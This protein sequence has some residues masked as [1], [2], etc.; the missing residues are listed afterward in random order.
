MISA[1]SVG[2][3]FFLGGIWMA[4][5]MPATAFAAVEETSPV[6]LPRE[7]EFFLPSHPDNPLQL[8]HRLLETGTVRLQVEGQP[9]T[10][11]EDFKV[12]ARS[13]II[14]PLQPWHSGQEPSLVV[15]RYRYLPAGLPVRRDLW[16]VSPAPRR[17]ASGQLIAQEQTG[18][19]GAAWR[20]GQLNVTG[21]KTVQVNSGSRREMTVDQNLRLTILGQLTE[22]IGVRAFLSD[23]N[24]PVI[25]EGNTEELRDIDKVLVE[26]RAKRWEATLGDF[27]AQRKG[28]TFGDYRRKLQGFSVQTRSDEASV[29]VLAGSPRGLYKTLQVRGQEANQGPYYLGA[30]AGA[31]NLFIVA[32]SERVTLDGERLTRGADRDYTID[33]VA[34]TVTFTFRR[35]ITAESTIVVEYEQGEGPFGRTVVGAGA[36]AEFEVPGLRWQGRFKARIIRERDDPHRLRTG[37]LSV[38]DEAVLATAGD[39]PY[40]AVAVGVQVVEGSLGLYDRTEDSGKTIYIYNATGGDYDLSLYFVGNGE[41]DYVLDFITETGQRI[42]RHKGDGLGNYRIGR[43]LD[44]PQQQSMT[45]LTAAVGDTTGSH[46]RAE[47]NFSDMDENLLS[48]QDDGDNQATAGRLEGRWEQQNLVAGELHVTGFHESQEA[49][50]TPFQVHKTVFDFDRWGLSDRARRTGFIAE[51]NMETGAS[52]RWATGG[53]DRSMEFRGAWGRLRHGESVEAARSSGQLGWKVLG[54]LGEHYESRAKAQDGMDPLDIQRTSRQHLLRWQ[55]GPIQPEIRYR[56][57]EWENAIV[58]DE[59]AAGYALEEVG[60]ALTSGPGT[61]WNWRVDYTR[62]LADSLRTGSW[63]KERDGRTWT[64]A[65]TS[66]QVLGMRMVGEGTLRRTLLAE[67]PE[68]KTRLGRVNLSGRWEALA[69]DWSLGYRVDNS[70]LHVLDRQ[71]VYVGERLGD[72]NE[73]GAYMGPELGDFNLVQAATDSLLATT[74]VLTDL[75]WRQGFTFLGKDRWYGAWSLLTLASVEGRSTR[76]D[77]RDLLLLSPSAVFEEGATVLGDLNFSEEITFLQHMP[78]VDLRSRFEYRETMDRQYADHPEDRLTRGWQGNATVNVGRRTS[79]RGR[80]SHR[81]ESQRSVES[82]ASSRRSYVSIVNEY[83]VAW[84]FRPSSDLRLNLAVSTLDRSDAV[85]GVKQTEY[86]LNPNA[87]ALFAREWTLRGDLRIS[88]VTSEKPAGASRPWFYPVPG[89]NVEASVR[90]GWEPSPYLDMGLSYF[91]RKRGDRGWQHDFR[92]ESTAR[93]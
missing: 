15:I 10:E 85:S 59:R 28:T 92:L 43:P 78:T 53:T 2:F 84:G 4:G 40:L 79:L 76:E 54:L 81:L 93:F 74:A 71:L 87:R 63:R 68:Q 25:P 12:Q 75:H 14:I 66:P 64:A 83:E 50:F 90:L 58:R 36:G 11:G 91:G 72:Y 86:A 33:Y 82:Q 27:V 62:S 29:E 47:V 39:D 30:S 26:L 56:R 65:V 60:M 24:L 89:Q 7:T 57:Q 8:A 37:D 5:M 13:G 22:D 41:G 9:W 34:G 32:G 3:I 38:E 23:D 20:G 6:E 46:F 49:G 19:D 21:S 31:E 80:M 17:D 61:A 1:R 67:G 44:R 42:F 70:R 51:K 35:L 48:E 88:D 18:L 45:T 73:N 55:R 16:V 77:V 69:S 52:A